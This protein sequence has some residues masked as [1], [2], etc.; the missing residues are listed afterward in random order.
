MSAHQQN[1]TL[2][3][4][5]ASSSSS[6]LEWLMGYIWLSTLAFQ[7]HTLGFPPLQFPLRIPPLSP[8]LLIL[9]WPGL[10]P[11]SSF[12]F[13]FIYL[14]I[15][16][17]PRT[18]KPLSPELVYPTTYLTSNKHLK[19][20]SFWSYLFYPQSSPT[21]LVATV[22]FCG[23]ILSSLS[24]PFYLTSNPSTHSVASAFITSRFWP[25]LTIPRL[26]RLLSLA[27]IIATAS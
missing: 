15:S 9:V 26:P 13:I 4:H 8:D 3:N 12:L 24:F 6:Y 11:W 21:Q 14:G 10:G 22:Y 17:T 23:V 19:F 16:F 18:V 1:P 27:W 7:L 2:L 25:L 5:R 20:T